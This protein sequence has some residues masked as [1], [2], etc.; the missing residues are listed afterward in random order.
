MNKE[1]LVSILTCIFNQAKYFEQ[2]I[3]SVL[4]Q[5]Y[6]NW[7]WI[8][9]DDG[10]TDNLFEIIKKYDEDSRIKYFYQNHAGIENLT[11]TFNK[12]LRFCNGAFVA[13]LD[14]DDYWTERKLEIQVRE[15]T[16]SNAVL[17][18]GAAW[19][20][21]QKGEKKDYISL[22]SIKSIAIN[23]PRGS[24]LKKLLE[25]NSCF[26]VN[27]TVMYKK[28]TLLSIGGFIEADGVSQDFPTWVRLSLEGTFSAIPACLGYYRKHPSSISLRNPENAF[29]SCINFLEG[30]I[31][32]NQQK[33]HELGIFYDIGQLQK[34]WEEIRTYL[35]YNNALYFMMNGLFKEASDEFKRF[36]EKH[37]S[38]K[39]KLIYFSINIS[40]AVGCDLVNPLVIV[41]KRLKLFLN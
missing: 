25:E 40:K 41:K 32:Q 23:D 9:L 35:P 11:K 39:H 22:P 10:S 34:Q 24:A 14:G 18:Y 17:S 29:D 31:M 30:F 37:P 6:Q 20:I 2:T 1:P 28:D 3:D 5:T 4:K 33:L 26:I 21:N 13:T 36:L 8:I 16:E 12:A 19:L 15:F 27:S 7:E 38:L